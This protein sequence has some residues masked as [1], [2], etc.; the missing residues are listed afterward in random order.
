MRQ[1]PAGTSVLRAPRDFLATRG[2]FR[3]DP[4]PQ[5]RR[6]ATLVVTT[7]ALRAYA[8]ALWTSCE[9]TLAEVVAEQTVWDA[10]DLSVRLL[11][12]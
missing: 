3:P 2:L 8:R 11:A 4:D 1:R 10:G 9:T 7:P 6:I 12:R 5:A